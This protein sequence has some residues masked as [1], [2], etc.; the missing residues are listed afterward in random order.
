MTPKDLMNRAWLVAMI[1]VVAALGAALHHN[2][3]DFRLYL[4]LSNIWVATM[5][6]ARYLQRTIR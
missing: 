1:W 6:L 2:D 4:L 3:A 5:F